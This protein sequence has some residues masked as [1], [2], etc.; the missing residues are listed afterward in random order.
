MKER[1]VAVNDLYAFVLPNAK[2]WQTG[3]QVHFNALG[4][5]NLAKR[6]SASLR[7]ALPKKTEEKR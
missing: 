7:A 2:E 6:V 3:D 1:K 4:N 5:Q